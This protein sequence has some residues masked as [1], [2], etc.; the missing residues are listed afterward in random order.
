MPAF[1]INNMGASLFSHTNGHQS[2]I[3]TLELGNG[4]RSEPKSQCIMYC[5]AVYTVNALKPQLIHRISICFNLNH[6]FRLQPFQ[7]FP[8]YFS[9]AFVVGKCIGEQFYSLTMCSVCWMFRCTVFVSRI[10]SSGN[11][12]IR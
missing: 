1:T 6:L 8:I 4:Y 3:C 9:V 5:T 10:S 2:D 11:F 12:A 7:E